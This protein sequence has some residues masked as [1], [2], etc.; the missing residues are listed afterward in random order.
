M[1]A[2][3][4]RATDVV[5]ERFVAG[6]TRGPRGNGRG[7]NAALRADSLPMKGKGWGEGF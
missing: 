6:R 1:L 7:G 5:S 4:H 3:A 2:I